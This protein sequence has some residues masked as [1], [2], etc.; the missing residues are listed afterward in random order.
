MRFHWTNENT[1]GDDSVKGSPLRAG[2]AW[3]HF[4]KSGNTSLATEWYLWTKKFS[5]GIGLA[6]YEHAV[7]VH[8]SLILFSFYLTLEYWPLEKW[9]KRVTKRKDDKYGNGRTIG[10]TWIEG[11]LMV[12]LWNDPME[13][14]SADPKWWHFSIN[15]A[16]TLLGRPE[17]SERTLKE[18]VR[19]LAMPEKVY[20]VKIKINESAW[21][22]PR[23]PWPR[24]IVR[25]HSEVEGGIPVPGKGTESYNCGEDAIYSQTSPGTTFDAALSSLFQSVAHNRE[26]YPL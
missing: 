8:L 25:T 7:S 4:G 15:P 2:R 22:R 1:K 3:L 17:Y 5:A 24:K 12:D 11:T 20:D 9:L 18:G 6:D 13:W 19:Q 14:R 26:H 23:W 10:F 16:D 21:K